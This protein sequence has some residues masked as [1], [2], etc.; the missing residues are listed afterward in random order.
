MRG[1]DMLEVLLVGLVAFAAAWAYPR[2]RDGGARDPVVE[3]VPD[4]ATRALDLR[5]AQ[6]ALGTAPRILEPAEGPD[7]VLIVLDTVRADRM[8]VYGYE[9]DTTPAIDRW[10]RG[11]RVYDRMVSNGAWTLPSHASLFTGKPVIAHGARGTPLDKPLASPLRDGSDTVARALRKAGWR[12]VGVAANRAFLARSWGLAQGFDVWLNEALRVADDLPYTAGDRVTAL[13]R[14]VLGRRRDAPVFLFLNYMDAHAPWVPRRGY[15]A[16]DDRI[17]G[18]HLPYGP[19]WEGLTD[20]L[21]GERKADPAVL[22]SWRAAYDAELRYLDEQV[23]ALLA[24]L[25]SLGIDENDYVFL[26]SDHGE[27]LGEH[28]LVEHSKDLYDEVLRVPLLVKGPGYTPGRDPTPVQTHDVASLVLAAAGLPP[29]DGA[30]RTDA[31]QVSELYWSRHRDLA[32]P[33]GARFDRVRRAYR[34][35]DRKLLLGSDGAREAY[36][37]A[38]DPRESRDLTGGVEWLGTVEAAA[39]AWLAG[40]PEAPDVPL[41]DALDAEA[42]RALGYVE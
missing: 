17:D 33:Y 16:E 11:A 6:G 35:G 19:A 26:L 31:L 29:L 18:P 4:A 36:D 9:R 39:D 2:G 27:Y 42:L 13:A 8:G 37:L 41:E 32:E 21:M 20:R 34:L 1:R 25:P 40:H 5:M 14:E 38:A 15:V 12:T 24:A 10:A 22:A 23:G 30:E 28:H 7:I 3:W